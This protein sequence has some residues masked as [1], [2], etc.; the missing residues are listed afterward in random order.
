MASVDERAIECDEVERDRA[1]NMVYLKNKESL[2]LIS[3]MRRQPILKCGK[4]YILLD[5]EATAYTYGPKPTRSK[6]RTKKS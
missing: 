4:S 1:T 2:L 3:E 6:A 5:G